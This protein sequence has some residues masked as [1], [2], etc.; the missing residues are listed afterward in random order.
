MARAAAVLGVIADSWGRVSA[1]FVMAA[2]LVVGIAVAL[3]LPKEHTVAEYFTR[4]AER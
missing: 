1:F 3:A 4:N 2:L